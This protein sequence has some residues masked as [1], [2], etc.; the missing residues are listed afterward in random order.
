M[1]ETLVA[2]HRA[3]RFVEER[4]QTEVSVAE[5]AAAAGYSLFHFVRTFNGVVQHTPY[6][7]L[8][9]RRLSEAADQ[10]Q[11]GSEPVGE[12]G[13]RYG[14]TSPE[15]FSRAFRRMF[16]VQPSQ[17]RSAEPWRRRLRLPALDLAYL[18]HVQRPDFGPARP[19]E[20]GET[21][22]AGLMAPLDD[23]AAPA[24]LWERL[25][26]AVGGEARAF[27]GARLFPPPAG[28]APFY[29]AGFELAAAEAPPPS[30]AVVTLPAG[31]YA[32]LPAPPQALELSLAYLYHTWL[33]KSGLQPLH[34]LE[35][36]RFTGPLPPGATRAL[37][38]PCRGDAFALMRPD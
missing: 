6:D 31:Q 1:K 24:R 28:A 3:I 10:L 17:W 12:T 13:L 16:G 26:A 38:I 18:Q 36:D 25:L 30:L 9:R 29:L 11:T 15:G 7:Y 23:G 2:I 32:C 33:P 5:M 19:C 22:L 20:R 34:Q 27:Y 4:L 8:V 14:F 37:L 21:R 35:I